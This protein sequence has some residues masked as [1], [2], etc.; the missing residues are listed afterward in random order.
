[1]DI[2]IRYRARKSNSLG[3]IFVFLLWQASHAPVIINYLSIS[4]ARDWHPRSLSCF[5]GQII[6]F[7]NFYNEKINKIK[8]RQ[9]FPAIRYS[10][11][12][13]HDKVLIKFKSQW[14]THLNMECRA[15]SLPPS[16]IPSVSLHWRRKVV[17]P[18]RPSPHRLH[19]WD[20]E[21]LVQW[22]NFH[23]TVQQ[24]N[25]APIKFVLVIITKNTLGIMW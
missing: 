15:L 1:M 21:G 17:S 11:Y 6:S 18:P 25:N 20:G 24:K 3:F 10:V 13:M 22:L 8:Y 14:A 12:E 5:C 7:W 4:A 9:K 2:N 16:L 19:Q 23:C